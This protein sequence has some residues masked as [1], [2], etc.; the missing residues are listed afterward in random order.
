MSTRPR[1]TGHQREQIER[2]SSMVDLDLDLD[3]ELE[4]VLWC[5]GDVTAGC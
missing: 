1:H 2:F 4:I 3:L 5:V